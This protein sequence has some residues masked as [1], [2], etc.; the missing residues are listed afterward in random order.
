MHA[1][2]DSLV[3]PHDQLMSVIAMDVDIALGVMHIGVE[4]SVLSLLTD[5]NVTSS[6]AE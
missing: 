3:W 4:I 1:Q 2:I 6:E 5:A